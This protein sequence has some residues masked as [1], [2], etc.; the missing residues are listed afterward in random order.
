MRRW[1]FAI[2]LTSAAGCTQTPVAET[3]H[4]PIT[5]PP[6]APAQVA[7]NAEY[8]DQEFVDFP[9]TQPELVLTGRLEEND[10]KNYAF[11][12]LAGQ[13]I[14]IKVSEGVTF[15]LYRVYDWANPLA[16]ESEGL[17]SGVLPRTQEY[18]LEIMNNNS[19]STDYTVTIT[20]S[21]PET[22]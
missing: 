10:W 19:V 18:L 22:P 3:P 11:N 20:H 21:T 15:S 7:S 6:P 4:L 8:P 2:V 13:D 17:W 5:Q 1:I 12:G 16:K 14:T 9:A